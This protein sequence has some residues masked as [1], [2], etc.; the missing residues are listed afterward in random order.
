MIS[1]VSGSMVG[2]GEAPRWVRRGEAL[3]EARITRSYRAD[4]PTFSAYTRAVWGIGPR[5]AYNLIAGAKVYR[6]ITEGQP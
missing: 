5:Y 3:E 4:Y 6:E 1:E 2:A